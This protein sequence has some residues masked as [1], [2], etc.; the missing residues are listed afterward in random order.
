[1]GLFRSLQK[2]VQLQILIFQ[3][4]CGGMFLCNLFNLADSA[5]DKLG[6]VEH[7]RRNM[8]SDINAKMEHEMNF[9][10]Q[11][12]KIFF[13]GLHSDCTD[14][15]ID[16][17][18][19]DIE[20]RL[21]AS[22]QNFVLLDNYETWLK[23]PSAVVKH[24]TIYCPEHAPGRG[25]KSLSSST[26]DKIAARAE[27]HGIALRFIVATLQNQH[28]MSWAH[29]R[30]N[31]MHHPLSLTEWMDRQMRQYHEAL[32]SKHTTEFCLDRFL[33]GDVDSLL[34]E[35]SKISVGPIDDEP[36]I[37]SRAEAFLEKKRF[38]AAADH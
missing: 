4:G 27:Q 34:C 23:D 8:Y 29:E 28:H 21:L 2:L 5:V 26:L 10:F 25:Q 20:I 9:I 19:A 37:R 32:N 24:R 13:D 11:S 31:A 14:D 38:A 15:Q 6:M 1:M 3:P 33:D 7:M 22:T 35:M 17:W 12:S 18:L 16:L 36:L 30:E